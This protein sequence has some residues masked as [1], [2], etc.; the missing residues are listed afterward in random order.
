LGEYKHIYFFLYLSFQYYR[1][2]S[3][4]FRDIDESLLYLADSDEEDPFFPMSPSAAEAKERG[5]VGQRL[6]ADPLSS[7]AAVGGG[8]RGRCIVDQGQKTPFFSPPKKY[9]TAEEI[10]SSFLGRI[11]TQVSRHMLIGSPSTQQAALSVLADL[12]MPDNNVSKIIVSSKAVNGTPTQ[13]MS[14]DT[15]KLLIHS[16]K[17]TKSG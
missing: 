8:S 11:V 12:A 13:G 9:R 3:T 16:K 5:S 6:L 4:L 14:Q 2:H 10:N 17:I 7:L 15:C 1:L